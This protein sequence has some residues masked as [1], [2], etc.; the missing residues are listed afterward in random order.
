MRILRR[1]RWA[2][3]C[4]ATA[5]TCAS[6]A[7]T[8]DILVGGS[9]VGENTISLQPDGTTQSRLTITV[10]GTKITSEL[11]YQF[12]ADGKVKRH[13]FLEESGTSKVEGSYD[14]M[15]LTVL[16]NGKPAPT[17]NVPKHGPP[18]FSNLHPSL[19]QT[20]KGQLEK[21]KGTITITSVST[22]TPISADYEWTTLTV[23][24]GGRIEPITLVKL[25]LAGSV[26]KCALSADYT[27][28]GI[29]VPAQLLTMQE[30]G[31][32][33][34]F[35]DPVAKSK[36]LSQLTHPVE[37]T[38]K[39]LTPMRDGIQLATTLALPKGAGKAPTILIRTP[40]GREGTM[41]AYSHFAQRGY[42]VVVQ[43]TRGKG[44]SQGKFDP[45]MGEIEDG[46]DTLEW[47]T[48]QQWSDGSVGMI[49]GSY[50]GYVQWAAAMSK[51]PAL[52]C[53]IPQVSPPE[54]TRNVPWDHGVFML[55]PNLWWANI[56]RGQNADLS[57]A[58]T[59][60]LDPKALY[61]LP[62]SRADD[63]FF[64][65][66]LPF[67]DS[68]LK[69]PRLEDWK[70]A[71]TQK[72]IGEVKIP[73]LH[74]SGTWDGDGIGTLL[75]WQA[76]RKN[77]GNQWMVFGPWPHGF[78]MSTTLGDLDFG[79]QSVIDLTTMEVRFFDQFLK[80][81]EVGMEKVPRVKIFATGA[82]QWFSDRDLPLSFTHKRT[83]YLAGNSGKGFKSS[84]V[85]T[86]H[87]P[88]PGKDSYAYHPAKS[89]VLPASSNVGSVRESD[90]PGEM[91]TYRTE[92]FTKSTLVTGP[93]EVKLHAFTTV[94][95]ATFF[96]FLAEETADGKH[97]MLGQPGKMRTTYA[98]GGLISPN[99]TVEL[100]I[101]PWLFA[102][103]L[104]PG[105]RLVLFITSD[106]FPV[107]A[108]NPGTGEPDFSA[109]K[110][111]SAVHTVRRG[112]GAA[113]SLSYYA[114]SW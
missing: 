43:D 109:T 47:I 37:T 106:M 32:E 75:N 45:F 18:Y 86:E 34:I 83:V 73:V 17:G 63:V 21:P 61:T 65:R 56:V 85:L 13:R 110:L 98:T 28:R 94:R 54:P 80:K 91:L 48:K 66:N 79:P 88:A 26:I 7:R 24:V 76:Q 59:L 101:Q 90:F 104:K 9:K 58:A 25:T 57:T 114:Y 97:Q 31:W 2:L 102:H 15:K 95:D 72:G 30:R 113:S 67:F 33:G 3:I 62:L 16:V 52:K 8:L 14:G 93:F 50:L 29:Q 38:P 12:A 42:N 96:A 92:K 64:G 35:A 74:V 27:V 81:K 41:F 6:Y 23:S 82:N 87:V 22:F 36:E 103:V 71:I 107:F 4:L 70:G 69:R 44:D 111:L 99:R 112:K 1:M 55:Q 108:R 39:T 51:H 10:P 40:Y 78:N 11:D 60:S 84:G 20:L 49:G 89:K 53:I 19:F 105:S 46:Y 68:W 5:F 77:G 100:D